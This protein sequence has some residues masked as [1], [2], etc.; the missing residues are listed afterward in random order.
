MK[1]WIYKADTRRGHHSPCEGARKSISGRRRMETPSQGRGPRRQVFIYSASALRAAS[2]GGAREAGSC[3]HP[4]GDPA[5]LRESRPLGGSAPQHGRRGGKAVLAWPGPG[6]CW[7]LCLPRGGAAADQPPA[8]RELL[9]L[10]PPHP[11]G[12]FQTPPQPPPWV[13]SSPPPTPAPPSAPAPGCSVCLGFR[14]LLL[15]AG[16]RNRAAPRTNTQGCDPRA[17]RACLPRPLAPSALTAP[18]SVLLTPTPPLA[19]PPPRLRT[20]LG[21]PPFQRWDPGPGSAPPRPAPAG[22]TCPLSARSRRGRSR[23]TSGAAPAPTHSA[24]DPGG[25]HLGFG[26]GGPGCGVG[27]R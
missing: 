27:G 20:R 5:H 23:R 8:P 12:P 1:I 24:A 13:P 2:Q 21:D 11:T 14:P 9:S 18:S 15:T 10:R 25:S 26:S 7:G 17:S 6:G 3:G 16:T 19:L 22:L 4:S